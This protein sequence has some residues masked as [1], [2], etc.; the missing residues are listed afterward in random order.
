MIG[1]STKVFP[2]ASWMQG[3]NRTGLKCVE[4][5]FERSRFPVSISQ[6]KENVKP[7]T[8]YFKASAFSGAG[9]LFSDNKHIRKSQEQK[10]FGEIEFCKAMGARELVIIFSEKDFHKRTVMNF[11]KSINRKAN[12]NGVE[13]LAENNAQGRFS[14]V[15]DLDFITTQAKGVKI[16]LNADNLM[17]SGIDYA[18]FIKPLNTK[19]KYVRITKNSDAE[20]VRMAVA[21]CDI[22]KWI[23]CDE[24][25]GDAMESV[26]MLASMGF[27][28]S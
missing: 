24:S 25:I 17:Q 2:Y 10:V 22:L 8:T 14:N 12:F 6:V 11:A 27:D 3:F 15:L 21:E 20:I 19:I 23:V 13:L 1:L 28:V 16:C 7:W 18:E 26:K 4:I 9:R 5:D